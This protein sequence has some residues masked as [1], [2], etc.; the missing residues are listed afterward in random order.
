MISV[1]IGKEE[2][3]QHKRYESDRYK[4]E[5]KRDLDDPAGISIIM[6]D[7]FK[8]AREEIEKQKEIDRNKVL[9]DGGAV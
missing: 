6:A 4:I 2:V 7:L 1:T 8:L 9:E 5:V 3:R